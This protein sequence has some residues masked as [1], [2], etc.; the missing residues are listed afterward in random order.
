MLD[1]VNEPLLRE[2]FNGKGRYRD[3]NSNVPLAIVVAEQPGL[4]GC[5]QALR[6]GVS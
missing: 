1:L 2:R 5:L 4:L 6:T 3:F